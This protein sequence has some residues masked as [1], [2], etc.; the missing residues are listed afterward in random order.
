MIT[1]NPAVLAQIVGFGVFL[2][3]GLYVLVRGARRTP[4]IVVSLV[5]LFAQAIYF[6][7][8]ALTDTRADA[9][10]FAALQRWTLWTSV[11]PA[12]AW[13]HFSSL[14]ARRAPGR[15]AAAAI[16][17]PLVVASYTAGALLFLGGALW[18]AARNNWS[19]PISVLPGYLGLFVGLGALGY[20]VAHFGLLLDGQNVQRDFFYNFTGITLM[21]L[22]YGGL[23]LLA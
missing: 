19:L 14:V 21:N 23:L 7:T 13:F 9:A 3:L 18:I 10:A 6:C 8:G 22:L 20:G 11:L 15:R 12:A 1:D 17:P 4:L 2:W 16:F 5:G